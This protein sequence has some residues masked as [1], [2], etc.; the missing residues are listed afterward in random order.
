MFTRSRNRST[1]AVGTTSF[2]GTV[3][4]NFPR[5]IQ[6]TSTVSCDSDVDS[7]ILDRMPTAYTRREENPVEHVRNLS[8]RWGG[9][10]YFYSQHPY[11]YPVEATLH[12]SMTG[13]CKYVPPPNPLQP[14]WGG[15]VDELAASLDYR[16]KNSSMLLVSLKEIGSTVKMFKDPFSLMSADWR[17]VVKNLSARTLAKKSAN[18]WLEQL[19]GW[20]SFYSDLTSFSKACGKSVVD[21]VSSEQATLDLQRFSATQTGS[22]TH[23]NVF[24]GG[25]TTNESMWSTLA[26]PSNWNLSY[27]WYPACRIS[28]INWL[29]THRMYCRYA[30]P[31]LRAASLARK[32]LG[33]FELSS[34]QSLRDTL[35]EVIPY[36]FVVDWFVDTRGI[37]SSLNRSRIASL[38]GGHIGYSTKYSVQYNVEYYSGFNWAYECRDYVTGVSYPTNQGGRWYIRDGR[39]LMPPIG[40]GE[41]TKYTRGIGFPSSEDSFYS[42]LTNRGLS[43]S[44]LASGLS[45]VAQRIL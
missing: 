8:G 4:P 34:W 16:S 36:S 17:S 21:A 1:P 39:C 9:T 3:V 5:L 13:S 31:M 32:L 40:N 2:G 38:C 10:G 15:L 30:G 33:N 41:Y 45:L 18:V 28:R 24:G 6:Q 11:A 35:W 26:A 7:Y 37:W 22:G 23:A 12:F 20:K 19:Y 44:Q 14:N 43:F 25:Y 42:N 27:Y 29:T